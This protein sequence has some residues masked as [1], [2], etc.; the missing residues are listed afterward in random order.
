MGKS[1]TALFK[2][3]VVAVFVYLASYDFCLAG[4]DFTKLLRV[5]LATTLC[6]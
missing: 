3:Q 5:Q 1:P 6:V 2:L 4:S